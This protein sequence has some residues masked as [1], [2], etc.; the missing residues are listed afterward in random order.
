MLSKV[1][2]SSREGMTGLLLFESILLKKPL[3]LLAFL[4]CHRLQHLTM[5][6]AMSSRGSLREDLTCAICCDLFRDPVMLACMHHFCKACIC[7][8]WRGAQGPVSCPQ[9][10]K[11]FD[12][13]H[14]QTNYLVATLVDKIRASLSDSH[15]KN[16]EVSCHNWAVT[17]VLIISSKT[18]LVPKQTDLS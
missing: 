14:F 2:S 8:Y 13:K 12:S 15:V 7:R 10:R 16:L 4:S 18:S 9:C 5:A 3:H 1:F 17:C 11:E 6:A